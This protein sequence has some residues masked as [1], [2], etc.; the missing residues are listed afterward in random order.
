[1]SNISLH[2]ELGQDTVMTTSPTQVIARNT[3]E[4][5]RFHPRIDV[6]QTMI[7]KSRPQN[8]TFSVVLFD[9]LT[10]SVSTENYEYIIQ[11]TFERL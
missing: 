9:N 2:I 5:G 1:M 8:N 10:N 11:M 6:N 3:R 7:L 4:L